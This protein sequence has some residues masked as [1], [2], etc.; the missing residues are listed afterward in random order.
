MLATGRD[1]AGKSLVSGST[2]EGSPC[3]V[4]AVIGMA[5]TGTTGC[6]MMVRTGGKTMGRITTGTGMTGTTGGG[7]TG[8]NINSTII[9]IGM[10]VVIDAGIDGKNHTSPKAVSWLGINSGMDRG[11]KQCSYP[12]SPWAA[13][14]FLP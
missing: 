9:T 5:I 11:T 8:Y 7:T 6:G 4:M 12:D 14:L 1:I 13:N 10:M 2:T 3:S